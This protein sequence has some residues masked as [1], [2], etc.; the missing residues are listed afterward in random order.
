MVLDLDGFKAGERHARPRRRR[1]AAAGGD[2]AR[3]R[4]R[5]PERHAGRLGGDEFAIIQAGLASPRDAAAL[6]GRI[7]DAISRPFHI[8]GQEVRAGV[9]VGISLFPDDA[10]TPGGLLQ[11]ADLALYRAKDAGRGR[12]CF[13]EAAMN[14]AAQARRQLALDLA[15]ALARGDELSLAFQPQ[16]ELRTRRLVG[17]E[18]LLRWHHP[19]RGQIPPA[20]IVPIAESTGL[21]RPLGAWVLERACAEANAWAAA[22]SAVPVAVNVSAAQLRDASFGARVEE[23]LARHKLPPAL[24]CLELTES[25]LIDQQLDGIGPLLDRLTGLGVR[26]AIDDFGTGYSSL[27][28]LRRVPV[29]QIKVDRSFV[30]GVGSDAESEAIVRATVQLARSLGKL[31]VAEGVETPAQHRFLR[32]LGCEL[33][34]GYL[35]GRPEPAEAMRLRRSE[36]PLRG[37]RAAAGEGA[38]P[39]EPG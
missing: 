36:T 26:I 21:I 20:E 37:R 18:A 25:L 31:V 6:A 34:Q 14:A 17:S 23:A 30:R 2:A 39:P 12:F 3:A 22:G 8:D 33:G 32:R 15:A 24:L 16:V 7:V 38:T 10:A 13:F 28:N 5:A 4:G 19:E 9:S 11:N 27:L 1:R 29:H 35:Y